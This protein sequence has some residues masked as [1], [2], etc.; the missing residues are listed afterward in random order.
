MEILDEVIYFL[1]WRENY[2]GGLIL[3]SLLLY[4]DGG[5]QPMCVIPAAVCCCHSLQMSHLKSNFGEKGKAAGVVFVD[6]VDL[7]HSTNCEMV[8]H[9][10]WFG[11]VDQ[12]KKLRFCYDQSRFRCVPCHL[13]TVYR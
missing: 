1:S 6:I 3:P 13:D 11:S 4:P 10:T 5:A 7:N 9:K 12:K 8:F 2:S